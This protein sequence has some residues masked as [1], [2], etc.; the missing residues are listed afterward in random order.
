MHEP[1]AV[2][3]GSSRHWIFALYVGLTLVFALFQRSLIY[4]PARRAH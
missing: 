1:M 4:V 2:A 3:R